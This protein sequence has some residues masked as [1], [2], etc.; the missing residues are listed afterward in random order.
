MNTRLFRVW[1]AGGLALLGVAFLALA[2]LPPTT[3]GTAKKSD[4]RSLA[5][6]YADEVRPILQKYWVDCHSID[7]AADSAPLTPSRAAGRFGRHLT[8]RQGAP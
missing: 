6:K 7:R 5:K 3:P 1:Y 8:R 4:K 2:L